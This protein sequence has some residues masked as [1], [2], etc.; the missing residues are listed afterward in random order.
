M[1]RLSL[2]SR[3][4]R[5]I[6]AVCAQV[7]HV[8]GSLWAYD[9]ESDAL[10]AQ[11]EK[12]EATIA[13]PPALLRQPGDA[14]LGINPTFPDDPRYFAPDIADLRKLEGAPPH[15]AREATKK[16]VAEIVAAHDWFQSERERLG[17]TDL[18]R[19][20]DRL[21]QRVGKLWPSVRD[22]FDKL[23]DMP[24]ETLEDARLKWRTVSTAL[25]MG[26]DPVDW[27]R[28]GAGAD[29]TDTAVLLSIASDFARL[30]VAPIL[31]PPAMPKVE[32]FALQAVG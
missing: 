20:A 14:A 18:H 13:V 19:Q 17:V 1:H 12:I 31:S 10:V 29:D 9:E 15:V 11:A 27:Q 21:Q 26:A 3:S 23:A 16:R 32:T 7:A 22:F 25:R 28:N 2:P 5:T 24:A 8:A 30:T 6:V 4:S